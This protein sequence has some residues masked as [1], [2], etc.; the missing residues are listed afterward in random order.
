MIQIPFSLEKNLGA[1]YNKAMSSVTD[2]YCILM[3]YDAMML[4]PNTIPLIDK[5]VKKYPDAALLTGY[6]SRSHTSSSQHHPIMNRGDVLGAIR[7]AEK[8][9]RQPMSVKNLTKN[10]TGFFMVLKKSTW[11]KYKFIEGIGCLGVDTDYWRQLIAGG[12]TILLMETVYV[13]H[14]YRLRNGIK[15]K[16]HLSASV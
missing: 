10:V 13:W 5:Y 1:A 15:D 4:T 14:T 12:E 9:E 16:R 11:E 6:A 2:D 7:I 3:D 8:L